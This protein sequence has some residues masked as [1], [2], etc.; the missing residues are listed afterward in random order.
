MLSE[1]RSISTAN[2]LARWFQSFQ[3][4]INID[5]DNLHCLTS[6]SNLQDI[7]LKIIRHC[8]PIDYVKKVKETIQIAELKERHPDRWEQHKN[9]QIQ[10]GQIEQRINLRLREI[11][12]ARSEQSTNIFNELNRVQTMINDEYILISSL[13]KQLQIYRQLVSYLNQLVQYKEQLNLLTFTNQ[14]NQQESIRELLNT[15]TLLTGKFQQSVNLNDLCSSMNTFIQQRINQ[16]SKIQKDEQESNSTIIESYEAALTKTNL[17]FTKQFIHLANIR[18]ECSKL[19]NRLEDSKREV[20]SRRAS[21][22]Q[23]QL[24]S[25]LDAMI[26]SKSV[27]VHINFLKKKVQ[28]ELEQ[29]KKFDDKPILR[30]HQQITE[31]RNELNRIDNQLNKIIQENP[32]EKLEKLELKIRDYIRLINDLPRYFHSLNI[33]HLSLSNDLRSNLLTWPIEEFSRINLINNSIESPPISLVPIPT[34][35][36]PTPLT[37][38]KQLLGIRTQ[39]TII[40]EPPLTEDYSLKEEN[41]RWDIDVN[42]NDEILIKKFPLIS[43]INWGILTNVDNQMEEALKQ[44]QQDFTQYEQFFQNLIKE[45]RILQYEYTEKPAFRS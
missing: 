30:I 45:I 9:A 6:N 24:M 27:E 28:T 32:L 3:S 4:D 36:P 5:G 37:S 35:T 11:Y 2:A 34:Q 16:F 19:R 25:I 22:E 7:W 41:Q 12:S 39:D 38:L 15:K 26:A 10:Q 29:I 31:Q 14:T 13:N 44:C 40:L 8:H 20:L 17:D 1:D 18:M 33:M 21:N 43:S 42:E 23:T